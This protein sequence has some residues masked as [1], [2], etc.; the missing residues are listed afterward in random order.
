MHWGIF[1]LLI[2]QQFRFH[3]ILTN[4]Y[5]ALNTVKLCT[6]DYIYNSRLNKSLP[7]WNKIKNW[8]GLGKKKKK[9][10]EI[11]GHLASGFISF[12][13]FGL[14]KW[15]ITKL[16]TMN[17][18]PVI[19]YHRGGGGLGGRGWE[20]FS[21]GTQFPG[22]YGEVNSHSWQSIMGEGHLGKLTANEGDL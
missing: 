8:K 6:T 20:D 1:W 17:W 2:T 4:R 12:S 16:K 22:G 11:T 15:S 10:Q 13:A 21:G 5:F 7:K 14:V 18:G 3:W 9:N 19:F